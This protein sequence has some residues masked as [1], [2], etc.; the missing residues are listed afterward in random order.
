MTRSPTWK[1]G[2]SIVFSLLWLRVPGGFAGSGGEGLRR[3]GTTNSA[4]CQEGAAGAGGGGAATI[5]VWLSGQGLVAAGRGR[6]RMVAATASVRWVIRSAS[7]T[8]R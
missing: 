3:A 1:V 8:S 2:R 6:A 7:H 5:E 4:R